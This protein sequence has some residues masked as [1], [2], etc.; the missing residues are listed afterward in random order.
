MKHIPFLRGPLGEGMFQRIP[1]P[2][3]VQLDTHDRVVV[4]QDLYTISYLPSRCILYPP[5]AG[6]FLPNV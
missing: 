1:D 3:A 4:R 5:S 6:S 2:L